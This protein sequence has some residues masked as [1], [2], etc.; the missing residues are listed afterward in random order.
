MHEGSFVRL[1]ASGVVFPAKVLDFQRISQRTYNRNGTDVGVGYNQLRPEM[2]IIATVYV[3]PSTPVIAAGSPDDVVQDARARQTKAEFES[4]Q[5]EVT[6]A[7]PGASLLGQ[8]EVSLSEHGVAYHGWHGRFSYTQQMA[9]GP[10]AL[11]SDLF[12]FGY[13]AGRWD[14]EYRFSYP[15]PLDARRDIDAFMHALDINAAPN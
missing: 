7:H 12:A 4:R 3:Y 14:L 13:L 11:H 15:A 1:T 9:G 2:P 5:R 8:E 6:N 10:A